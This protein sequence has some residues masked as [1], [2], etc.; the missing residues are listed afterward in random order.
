MLWYILYLPYA[1]PL[2]GT[3]NLTAGEGF[4]EH[5]YTQ[6]ALFSTKANAQD[7]LDYYFQFEVNKKYGYSAIPEHYEILPYEDK[8]NTSNGGNV[9][10]EGTSIATKKLARTPPS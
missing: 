3:G 1:E 5:F 6:T 2:E 4:Y 8:P 7:A 9:L 10:T